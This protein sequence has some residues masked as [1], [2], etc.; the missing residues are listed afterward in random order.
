MGKK[1]I[2]LVI[3]ACEVLMF[4]LLLKILFFSFFLFVGAS[5]SHMIMVTSGFDLDI[6]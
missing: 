1:S 4:N 3:T 5:S 2:L 6:F